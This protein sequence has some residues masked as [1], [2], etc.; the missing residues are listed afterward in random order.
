MRVATFFAIAFAAIAS[1]ATDPNIKIDIVKAVT[2]THEQKTKVNQK[3]SVNYNGTLAS[4]G[5]LFD[6]SYS[7]KEPFSF[8]LGK[9]EVIKG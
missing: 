8:T 1:A 3:I 2:C 5:K 9:G 6:S 7:R 4:N